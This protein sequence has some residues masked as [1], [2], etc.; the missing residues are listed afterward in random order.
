MDYKEPWMVLKHFNE[1]LN[2]AGKKGENYRPE[3]QHMEFQE[4]QVTVSQIFQAPQEDTLLGAIDMRY[5]TQSVKGW[6]DSLQIRCG[7]V[8][9]VP[10]MF[11]MALWHIQIMFP[12]L[13]C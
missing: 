3:K 2:Q 5:R 10:G 7:N 4:A 8:L 6:I 11:H 1:G 9:S 12:S 13:S